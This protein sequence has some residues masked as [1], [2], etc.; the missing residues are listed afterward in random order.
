M[1]HL[2]KKNKWE[3]LLYSFAMA[4]NL[5]P[6][7]LVKQVGHDGRKSIP[8]IGNKGFHI[9]EFIRFAVEHDITVTPVEFCPVNAYTNMQRVMAVEMASWSHYLLKQIKTKRGVITGFG[10]K[11]QGGHAMAFESGMVFDPDGGEP[12]EF[13]F[14]LPHSHNFVPQTAWIVEWKTYK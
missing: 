4:A 1:I 2:T 3:C 9:Q 12:F 6:G 11:S 13:T 14:D 8:G 7:T 10:L 5:D